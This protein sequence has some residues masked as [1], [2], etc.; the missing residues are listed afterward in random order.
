VGETTR[1]EPGERHGLVATLAGLVTLAV[2]TGLL[3]LLAACASNDS[4]DHAGRPPGPSSSSAVPAAIRPAA[5]VVRSLVVGRGAA[6]PGGARATG[7]CWTGSIAAPDSKAYRCL[8]SADSILDPCFATSP[9]TLSCYPDPWSAPTT[10]T[11]TAALPKVDRLAGVTRPW[12]M[13]LSDGARCVALTGTVT[14]VDGVDFGY[15]CLDGTLAAAP[16]GAAG[17]L[18][19]VRTATAGAAPRPAET[20]VT[21]IW[22]D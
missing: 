17:T 5:T 10:L 3:I 13:Q 2:A 11:L 7:S 15:R 19:H 14:V 9:T 4:T 20:T 22:R 21:A 12:A 8:T 6:T 1:T 16:T 18:L